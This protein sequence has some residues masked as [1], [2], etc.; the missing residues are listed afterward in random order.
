LLTPIVANHFYTQYATEIDRLNSE[1]STLNAQIRSLEP[2]VQRYNEISAELSQI[3]AQLTLLGELN[4]GT[5]RWSTNLDLLNRGFNDVNSVWITSM[6]PVQGQN[7]ELSGYAMY[8]NRI[9]QLADIFD[10]ATL[11]N[12]RSNDIREEEVYQFEYVVKDFFEDETIYTPE[13]VQGI[14]ELT[15]D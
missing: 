14:R 15:Q 5:L 8:R 12:V 9:P 4:Q 10:N 11:L 3:Q 6:S 13:S 1:V 7:M 2:T